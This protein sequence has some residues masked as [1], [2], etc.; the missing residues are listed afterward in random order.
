[1]SNPKLHDF[2]KLPKWT[3][4]LIHTLQNEL[5]RL[6]TKMATL[7][8]MNAIMC[9]PKRDWFTLP[10]SFDNY[11]TVN[12]WILDKDRPFSV[13]SLSKGDLLF[14][15]RKSKDKDKLNV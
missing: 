10:F 1:M 7:Q 4:E 6:N 12:L 2:N 14:I 5:N 13:C 9:E 8:N 15:G 3:Q 11:D